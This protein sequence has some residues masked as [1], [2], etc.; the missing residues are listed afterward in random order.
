MSKKVIIAIIAS[1]SVVG[2][3]T[4]NAPTAAPSALPPAAEGKY[5][6]MSNEAKMVVDLVNSNSGDF[7]AACEGGEASLIP[8][9]EEAITKLARSRKI[10]GNYDA[11]GNEAGDLYAA[12]CDSM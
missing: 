11:V 5:N 7:F 2:C 8:K 12:A 6:A 10:K 3:V 9:I 1:M 4:S